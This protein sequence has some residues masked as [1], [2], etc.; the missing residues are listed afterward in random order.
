MIHSPDAGQWRHTPLE[1]NGYLP[2]TT[3]LGQGLNTSHQSLLCLVPCI[4]YADPLPV[5]SLV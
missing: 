4:L 3:E 1:N 2:N 5:S